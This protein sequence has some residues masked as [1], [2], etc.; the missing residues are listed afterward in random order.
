MYVAL[1]AQWQRRILVDTA[2]RRMSSCTLGTPR[3]D[4]SREA[5][6]VPC[7]GI[8]SALSAEQV[9]ELVATK[10]PQ[11][12]TTPDTKRLHRTWVR[13][14]FKDAMEFLNRIADVAE[15]EG[16]H[17]DLHL[18]NWNRVRVELWTHALGGLTENDFILAMKVDEIA[19]Q[20]QK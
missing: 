2:L 18:T 4:V 6:C 9:A 17:P 3:R 19:E 12:T 13:P 11:W 7:E 8:G 14:N 10:T 5:R 1:I 20:G 16:H 15:K